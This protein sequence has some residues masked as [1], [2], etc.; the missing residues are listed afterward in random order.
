MED[1]KFWKIIE[2]SKKSRPADYVDSEYIK[3]AISNLSAEEIRDFFVEYVRKR[4]R[5]N[6]DIVYAL[7]CLLNKAKLSDDGFLYFR[8]WFLLQGDLAFKLAI[9]DPDSISENEVLIRQLSRE[10][11]YEEFH[12]FIVDAYQEKYN[13]DI[14]DHV[15]FFKTEEIMI[16]NISYD[17]AKKKLP[18]VANWLKKNKPKRGVE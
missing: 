6:V 7:G 1:K 14:Y 13:T 3:V 11:E 10:I 16:E 2:E 8:S 15:E 5:L 17:D 9:E 12:Y 4:S 18:K